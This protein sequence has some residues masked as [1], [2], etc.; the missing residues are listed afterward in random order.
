MAPYLLWDEE[1]TLFSCYFC[2]Y[3]SFS[4][5]CWWMEM[6]REKRPNFVFFSQ[7]F[8]YVAKRQN[9]QKASLCCNIKHRFLTIFFAKLYR[10]ISPILCFPENW[11]DLSLKGDNILRFWIFCLKLGM[12]VAQ[13]LYYNNKLKNHF[14]K[15]RTCASLAQDATHITE[16]IEFVETRL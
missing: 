5:A 1:S 9:I 11:H 16:N 14:W 13:A 7:L 10:L 12:D 4:S 2:Q 6:R 3:W 8:E 15:F